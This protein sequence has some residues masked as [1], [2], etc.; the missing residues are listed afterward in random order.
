MKCPKCFRELDEQDSFCGF[1]GAKIKQTKKKTKN[2]MRVFLFFS[3]LAMI[4]GT[5]LGFCMA[6]GIIDWEHIVKQNKFQWTN[7][8]EAEIEESQNE[9]EPL[10]E[11][12]R[13]LKEMT[14]DTEIS[15]E[16]YKQED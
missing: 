9:E 13:E 14:K 6:R 2:G 16:N 3:M 5:I 12:K 11:K 10:E 8:S 7:F 4:S 15:E 1:C